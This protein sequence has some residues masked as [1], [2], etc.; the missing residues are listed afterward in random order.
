VNQWR[1]L[2]SCIA[3][4]VFVAGCSGSSDSNAPS[5]ASQD[6]ALESENKDLVRR[7]YTEVIG[8]NKTD[9][10]SELFAADYIQHDPTVPTGPAGQIT[11]VEN[12]KMKIPDLVATIKHIGADGD[13]VAVHWHASAT[14]DDEATGQAAIDLYRVSDGKI[15]EHWDAFQDVPATTASGNSMFSDLYDYK[16]PKQNLTEAEEAANEETAV[17]AYEGLFEDRNVALLDEYWDP[18]YLQHNPQVPNGVEGLRG[19]IASFPP[20]GVK[21]EFIQTLADDDLVYTI[22]RNSSTDH[23]P[24]DIFRVVDNK[25]VEHWDILP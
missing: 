5:T 4:V 25:I 17:N 20:G 11:L 9:L 8:Q 24:T 23:V 16:E 10:V 1:G 18:N 7:F 13:Y 14:P 19:L 22:L 3:V 12:L 21:L 15:A 6:E 2:A